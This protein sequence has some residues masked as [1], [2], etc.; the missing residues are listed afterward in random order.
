MV[1][2]LS[3]FGFKCTEAAPQ[4]KFQSYG[5]LMHEPAKTAQ[6]GVPFPYWYPYYYPRGGP[7]GS[8]PPQAAPVYAE[9]QTALARHF[10]GLSHDVLKSEEFAN[11]VMFIGLGILFLFVLDAIVQTGISKAVIR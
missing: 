11:A 2:K 10:T 7:P 3:N 6:E 4:G 1:Q 8:P 5:E 9:P